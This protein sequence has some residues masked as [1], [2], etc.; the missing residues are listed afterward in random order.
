[1]RE[2]HI[3]AV[4]AILFELLAQLRG[5]ESHVDQLAREWH[6]ERDVVLFGEAGRAMD[7]IRMLVVEVPRLSAQWL[8]LMISHAEL[9]HNLWRM[10][11]GES[12]DLDAEVRDHLA[13][14]TAL[15]ASCRHLLV[16]GGQVLH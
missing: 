2:A 4:N 10:T 1:M 8:M 7:R 16:E 9:M 12:L 6:T 5:Y 13:C 11:R 14:V 3:P 15:A